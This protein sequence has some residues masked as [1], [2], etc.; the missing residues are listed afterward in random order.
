MKTFLGIQ[1]NKVAAEKY[2]IEIKFKL[3]RT[4]FCHFRIVYSNIFLAESKDGIDLFNNDVSIYAD[5]ISQQLKD[6]GY[7]VVEINDLWCD[8][9][10]Y[11]YLSSKDETKEYPHMKVYIH[12]NAI[13][14]WAPKKDFNNLLEIAKSNSFI[15]DVHIA[16]LQKVY[17]I[18]D[19]SYMNI[20][21][22]SEEQILMWLTEYKKHHKNRSH[23]A[24]EIFN[25]I[26]GIK[27]LSVEHL[28]FKDY[29]VEK[30]IKELEEKFLNN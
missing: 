20:L 27:R 14:G 17:N 23:G 11:A 29:I 19:N 2:G 22:N 9:C 12:P 4:S 6:K 16:Y 21:Q 30:Y 10:F 26:F 25:K 7:Y 13:S 15:S 3:P 18:D 8:D 5:K 1:N 24:A 28:Y